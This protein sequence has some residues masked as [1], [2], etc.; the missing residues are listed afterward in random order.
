MA[1]VTAADFSG[2]EVLVHLA[3]RG[4]SP[5]VATWEELL[6]ANV[7]DSF[8]LWDVARRA[9]VCAGFVICGSAVEYGRASE[10]YEFIPPDAPL[11]PTTGYGASKAAASMTALAFAREQRLEMALLRPFQAYGEGQHEA[12]FWPAL[13]AAALAG[14]DFPMTPGDR[15][16]TSCPSSRSPAFP[17][18]GCGN[19]TACR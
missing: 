15:C 1:E 18:S 14:R 4:V 8:R 3:A 19:A 9:Q 17:R 5:Q 16:A 12:T 13:K 10:R 2:S 11:E 6:E 7:L